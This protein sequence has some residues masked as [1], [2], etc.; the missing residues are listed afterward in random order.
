MIVKYET[1][2]DTTGRR[3]GWTPIAV[4][5]DKQQPHALKLLKLAQQCTRN[6]K[7]AIDDPVICDKVMNMLIR[8]A[9]IKQHRRL[10]GVPGLAEHQRLALQDKLLSTEYLQ[11]A[12]AVALE[13]E[14]SAGTLSHFDD[15]APD[16]GRWPLAYLSSFGGTIAAGTSEIPRNSLGERVLGL[17]KSK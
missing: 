12:A 5:I 15:N 1:F 8:Q 11:D 4:S 3:R 2:H 10:R 6:G 16:N 7:P 9:G 14:G 17:D 13:I